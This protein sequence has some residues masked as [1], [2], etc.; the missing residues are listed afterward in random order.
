MSA[1]DDEQQDRVDR[2]LA[3]LAS[4]GRS[5]HRIVQRGEAAFLDSEDD[6]L[7]RAGRSV[8]VDVSAVADRLP[9]AF[10][11]RYPNVPWR[12]I[13]ATRNR[14]AHEYD[15]VSDQIVWETLRTH[16]PDL[17]RTLGV[18]RPEPGRGPASSKALPS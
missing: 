13:R 5:A 8:I 17:L 16:L 7:R 4:F 10:A 1:L 11:A 6:L 2:A 9:D 15:G 3:D 14:T 18:E 12:E